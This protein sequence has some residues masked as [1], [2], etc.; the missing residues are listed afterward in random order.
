MTDP[1]V[2][3]L[4]ETQAEQSQALARI[5]A[6]LEDL[7][8]LRAKVAELANESRDQKLAIRWLKVAGSAVLGLVAWAVATF[9]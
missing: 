3:Y 5:E 1:M 6:K 2:Q 7:P 9:K 4:V 8:E